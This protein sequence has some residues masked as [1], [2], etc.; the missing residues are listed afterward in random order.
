MSMISTGIGSGRTLEPTLHLGYNRSRISWGAVIAGAVVAVATTLLLSLLGAAMGAG[1]IHGEIDANFPQVGHPSAAVRA[2]LAACPTSF[3][4]VNGTIIDALVSGAPY[5]SK[6]DISGQVYGLTTDV[7]S[8]GSTAVLMTSASVDEKVV[9]AFVRGIMAHI[10]DLETKHRVLSSLTVGEMAGDNIP[11][12]FHPAANQI[13][14]ALQLVKSAS[15]QL[16]D[17]RAQAARKGR[18]GSEWELRRCSRSQLRRS[19]VRGTISISLL[20]RDPLVGDETTV[21]RSIPLVKI[22][23]S[24]RRPGNPRP[25]RGPSAPHRQLCRLRGFRF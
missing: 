13:Y 22:N 20:G 8:F 15:D 16:S 12:P 5:F 24:A 25:R 1:S 9:A 7:P 21:H 17:R 19:S 3:V 23:L 4:A 6:G 11:A 10:D 2:Q 18:A 14:K